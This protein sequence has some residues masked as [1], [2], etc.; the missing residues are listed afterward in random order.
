MV[1]SRALHGTV[2]LN[3]SHLISDQDLPQPAGKTARFSEICVGS[4]GSPN[5]M[6]PSS[7]KS[8]FQ[9][10]VN[11]AFYL[12]I[13]V[14]ESGGRE[15]R[16]TIQV[17]W[18]PVWSFH[19]QWWFGLL[20]HLLVLVH[21]FFWSPQSMQPSTRNFS[22]TS[23]FCWLALWRC[24]LHF[25]AGLGTCPHCQRYQKLVQWPWLL[26]LIGQQTRLTW[27]PHRESME[28]CQEEDERNQTQQCRWP[29]GRYQSNLG[30]HYTWA[31]SQ[32]DCLHAMPH[33]CS[34]SCKRSPNQV[35]SI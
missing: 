10:K 8:S 29:E 14:P 17:A 21:C 20:C 24:W 3:C 16:H 26:C 5:P 27:T 11:V 6:Q 13:K 35:L 31:V 15:E 34:N 19:S 18:S 33:W 9:I 7:P 30:F 23:C 22:S 25:P 12:E 2:F 32:V 28:Y 1:Q 4:R